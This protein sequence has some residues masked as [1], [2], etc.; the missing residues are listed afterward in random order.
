MNTG[1][2]S[3]VREVTE[4]A[5]S[6]EMGRM[7]SQTKDVVREKVRTSL[8]PQLRTYIRDSIPEALQEVLSEEMLVTESNAA[9]ER[10]PA[11]AP[12]IPEEEVQLTLVADHEH[13]LEEV[14][15]N[16]NQSARYVYCIADFGGA[17]TLGNIGVQGNEVYTIPYNS[18]CAVVHAC[19]TESHEVEDEEVVK[20]R[21]QTHENVLD[22]ATEK[23]ETVLPV[24]FGTVIEGENGVSPEQKVEEWL[25]SDFRN[26][27]DSMDWIRG[28]KVFDIRVFYDLE[29]MEDMI[30][31]ENHQIQKLKEKMATQEPKKANMYKRKV[32]KAIR[33]ALEKNK[34]ESFRDLYG[35]IQN[36]V[37]DIRT[38]EIDKGSDKNILMNLSCLVVKDKVD[39]FSYKLQEIDNMKGFSVRFAGPLAPYGF[40]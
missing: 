28:K 25:R 34:E 10:I 6:R 17:I 16:G 3:N 19:S 31:R 2:N 12:A 20:S 13:I 8:L 33:E 23:F 32:E 26:L 4:Q 38:G 18:L 27:K 22:V 30:A 1:S 21:V 24:G 9:I 36:Q 5:M 7:L 14:R 39:S 40:V 15:D 29:I 11:A 37:E 35:M